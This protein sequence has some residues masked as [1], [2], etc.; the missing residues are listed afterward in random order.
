MARQSFKVISINLDVREAHTKTY[1]LL[2]PFREPVGFWWHSLAYIDHVG[3]K[4]YKIC[5]LICVTLGRLAACSTHENCISIAI[6]LQMLFASAF[7]D[8]TYSYDKGGI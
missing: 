5:E 6:I 1:F 7:L 8:W 3:T 4:L 2:N